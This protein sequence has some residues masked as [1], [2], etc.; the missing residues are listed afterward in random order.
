MIV[1]RIRSKT[2]GMFSS[3][4]SHPHFKKVGKLW[5]RKSDVDAHLRQARLDVYVDNDAE[6][7]SY[8]LTE[9]ETSVEPVVAWKERQYEKKQV[10]D[11]DKQR[12]QQQYLKRLR[13]ADYQKLKIEFEGE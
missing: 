1:Y 9:Q 8:A 7:V 11:G 12:K 5:K 10:Q 13:Y 4:G 6:I 3:G 2:T